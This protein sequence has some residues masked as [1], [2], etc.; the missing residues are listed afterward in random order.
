MQVAEDPAAGRSDYQGRTYFFCSVPCKTRFDADP[1]RYLK[2]A[3]APGLVQLGMVPASKAAAA[4]V[5][6]TC[7]MHPQIVRT[8]PGACPIC[9][10]ALEARV[11]SEEKNPELEDM[12]RRL[13]LSLPL[14]LPV[15]LLGMSHVL[16]GHGLAAFV[17]IAWSNWIQLA[18]T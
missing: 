15:V 13:W 3:P 16:P 8:A 5:E 4:P 10:M 1:Q 11:P 18:L 9:G 17:P 7:P 2:P 14:A 6:Y 12:G